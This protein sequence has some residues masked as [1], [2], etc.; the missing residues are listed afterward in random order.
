MSLVCVVCGR[1]FNTKLKLRKHH[2]KRHS[3]VR[4]Y[5]C[6]TCGQRFRRDCS[7]KAH[8]LAHSADKPYVCKYCGR[9]FVSHYRFRRHC[10]IHVADYIIFT[11]IVQPTLSNEHGIN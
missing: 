11:E 4:S 9:S 6:E 1:D 3:P 2:F 5:A 10:M 8:M 7:L